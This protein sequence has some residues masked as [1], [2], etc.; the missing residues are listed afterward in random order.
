MIALAV[1][2]F[3]P[4]AAHAALR[5]SGDPAL[6]APSL[7]LVRVQQDIP[8]VVRL[9]AE[10][11]LRAQR[12]GDEETARELFETIRELGYIV[13]QPDARDDDDHHGRIR[14]SRTRGGSDDDGDGDGDAD[15]DGD[16]DGDGG[17]D[18]DGDGDGGGD[19]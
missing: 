13:R 2:A 11:A 18:G 4:S 7:P 12:R 17:G 9:L 8:D 14:P 16:G 1:V 6:A 5:L 10:R 3:W 19:D 15:G